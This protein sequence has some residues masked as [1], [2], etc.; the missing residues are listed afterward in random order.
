MARVITKIGDVFSVKLDETTKKYFQYVANDITQL[1]SDIIRAFS[2]TYPI[3]E[4]PDISDI[5]KDEVEFFAHTMIN[6]GVKMRFWE[7][8]GKAPEIGKV[9][10][11]FRDSDDY[12][13]PE[14]KISHK[15][16]VW[17]INEK[18]VYVGKLEG[19]NQKAEI[20]IVLNPQD[21]VDRMRTGKYH[22]V[23]PGYQP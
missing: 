5:V 17:R 1:N 3:D 12:G 9:D 15:W 10:V 19:E 2:K 18:F 13:T 4:K 8:A 14:I 23:Y 20:G 16:Y 7:K 21:I 11:V 6:L 22:F